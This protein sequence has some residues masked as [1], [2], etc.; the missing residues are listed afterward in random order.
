MIGTQIQL[1]DGDPQNNAPTHAI[2][3]LNGH[4]YVPNAKCSFVPLSEVE[5][6]NPDLLDLMLKWQLSSALKVTNG[7]LA[8]NPAFV[9]IV[10]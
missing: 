6:K 3:K 9:H 1:Y 7:Y 2:L 10:K 8:Y 4:V 5:A